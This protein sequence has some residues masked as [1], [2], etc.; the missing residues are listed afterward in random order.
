MKANLRK[1]LRYLSEEDFY[2]ILDG[3]G[4]SDLKGAEQDKLEKIE[5]PIRFVLEFLSWKSSCCFYSFS[6]KID[7]DREIR[8]D[9]EIR[10]FFVWCAKN[11]KS[12]ENIEFMSR[13]SIGDEIA[14][15]LKA[16]EP[17]YIMLRAIKQ[18]EICA[19]EFAV[20]R[21]PKEFYEDEVPIREKRQL[22]E[23]IVNVAYDKAFK[24]YRDKK[25]N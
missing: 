7:H 21:T 25:R 11:F 18:A 8:Y 5:V 13:G 22:I 12:K 9:R 10:L 15:Y 17:S 24:A 4:M 3:F 6:P 14:T 1:L 23:T 2:E 20:I 16:L 19:K